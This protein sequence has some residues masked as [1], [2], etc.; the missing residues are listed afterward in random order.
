M[1]VN[2]DKSKYQS[3]LEL[4][5]NEI[6]SSRTTTQ[7]TV[8][9]LIAFGKKEPNKDKKQTFLDSLK[10]NILSQEELFEKY[11]KESEEKAKDLTSNS[12][13]EKKAKEISLDDNSIDKVINGKELQNDDTKTK[14]KDELSI[15]EIALKHIYE[16]MLE[17]Y[18]IYKQKVLRHSK[19]SDFEISDKSYNDYLLYEMYLNKI[20]NRFKSLT[21]KY[22]SE[23]DSK[24]KETEDKYLRKDIQ[25]EYKLQS[26]IGNTVA[27]IEEIQEDIIL[28]YDEM[29]KSNEEY[30]LGKM[31]I[32]EY[33]VRL[34]YLKSKLLDKNLE[35]EELEPGR[36]ELEVYLA[37]KE[38]Y[39]LVKDSKIG[40]SKESRS[41]RIFD[42]KTKKENEKVLDEKENTMDSIDKSTEELKYT[43]RDLEENLRED[44]KSMFKE[45]LGFVKS[46]TEVT[47]KDIEKLLKHSEKTNLGEKDKDLNFR[48]R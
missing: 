26:E 7:D 37:K 41:Y 42:G 13:K 39:E 43:E 35:L 5:L 45:E 18:Y 20:D 2:I 23:E 29:I 12:D 21:G 22:I 46:S 36:D 30:E 14:S 31:S 34:K 1:K 48:Q 16:R 11:V 47:K 32:S 15:N 40:T 44:N 33:D 27:S 25:S 3:E 28:I 4:A 8:L 9:N 10:S 6:V 17:E 38:E 24:I 19:K